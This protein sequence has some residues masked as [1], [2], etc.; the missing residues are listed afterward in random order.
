MYKKEKWIKKIFY[1]NVIKYTYIYNSQFF[2]D[3]KYSNVNEKHIS[4]NRKLNHSFLLFLLF[5]KY[6]FI[7]LI[8]WPV[9]I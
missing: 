8:S 7:Y 2:F 3:L 9:P 4:Q 1:T 5:L 6:F